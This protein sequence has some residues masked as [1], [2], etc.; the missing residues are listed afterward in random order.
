MSR[1]AGFIRTLCEPNT[2]WNESVGATPKASLN[3]S[4]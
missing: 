2:P 3:T 4:K 1:G